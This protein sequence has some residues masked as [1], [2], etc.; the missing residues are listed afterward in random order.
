MSRPTT[1][2]PDRIDKNSADS[3][4]QGRDRVWEHRFV[5]LLLLAIAG[6]W[7]YTY[8]IGRVDNK[9]TLEILKHIRK[10]F[11]SHLVYIDRA[12]LQAGQSIT[13]EGIRIAKPT[14]QG[15]RDVVRC[16]RVVCLGPIELL[17]LAQGQM[18]VQSVVADG[19]EL[20]VWPLS[21]GRFSVQELTSQK[22]ISSAL[23]T[24]E[25]RS[26][27]VRIGS[28]TG[29]SEQE[30]ICHDLRVHAGLGP[31]MHEG[32]VLPITAQIEASVSSSFFRHAN[33]VA[34]V[35]EDKKSWAAQGK[36]DKL[37]YSPRLADQLP[38]VLQQYLT[39]AA[40]FSG[41]LN[42]VFA[43]RCDQGA[44]SFESK[45]NISN[46]RL[47]H[48]K[49]PYPLENLSGEVFC[50]NGLL[51]LRNVKAASGPASVA[52]A[53]DLHGYSM[54]SPLAASIHVQNLSLDQRL[55]QAIPAPIQ[56]TWRKL[57]VS[58][59]V[60]A[61]A[62]IQF[63]GQRWIPRATVHAK[64][65]QL[66]PEFF[67]YAV[68]NLTG[69]FVY[70][71]GSINAHNLTGL[72]G[73]QRISGSLSLVQ[74]QPRWL[75]DLKLAADGPIAIDEALLKA[76]SPRDAPQCAMHKFILS[77]HPTGTVLLKQGHFVRSA[78]KPDQISRSLELTFSECSIK[79]DGFRYPIAEVHG[80]ATIDNE[81]LLLKDFVGRNDGARIKGHGVCQFQNSSLDSMELSFDARD[82]NLDEELQRALP[83]SVRGL[84]D[85]MQPSGVLDRVAIEIKRKNSAALDM[86]VEI[87]E[88]RETES[89][90]GRAVSI[91]PV[92][93]PYLINDVACS[94]IYRPGIV[95]IKSL[96]G[97]HD[98]SCLK[99]KGQF[100]LNTDG[101]WSGLTWLSGTRLNVDQS[102]LNCLPSYLREPLVRLDFRGPVS[103]DGTTRVSSPPTPSESIVREW[104]L[105]LQLEDG[106]LGGGGIASGIRGTVLLAGENTV[107]GP[108][109]FGSLMLDALAIKNIA[110]TQV[111]GPFAFSSQELLFGREARAWQIKNNIR[112]PNF[113]N[114]AY[115]SSVVNANYVVPSTNRNPSNESIAQA[116]FRGNLHDSLSGKGPLLNRNQATQTPD[117][118][119]SS[120]AE[121]IPALDINEND[122]EARALSGTV[123]VSGVESLTGQHRG[124]YG[125]RLVDADLQGCLVDLGETNPQ[126]TGRLSIQSNLR[127]ALTNTTALEGEGR[128]WLRHANLYELPAMIRLLGMLSVSPSQGAFDSAD[129][130][131][132]IDGERIPVNELVLDGNIVSLRGNGWVNMRR[133]LHLNLFAHVGRRNLVGAIF[134]P[135]TNSKAARLWQIE[136]D[137]SLSDPQI[138]R[139]LLYSLDKVLPETESDSN[140]R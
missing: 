35:S 126:A 105:E 58:G 121:D 63:D 23:P 109:A 127:G 9:L 112:Q 81:H 15:V 103:I 27:L 129:I 85:Q 76:L 107:N 64:D 37:E 62:S 95:D 42:S 99:T 60:D 10:E 39:H 83:R 86:R 71:N 46:G 33:I 135:I 80:E 29:K 73:D 115:D 91:R 30:I 84:W 65:G 61:R 20:C 3:I 70:E 111:R 55:Y 41:E 119:A 24:I 49:V 123:Y 101:T 88:D 94:I 53:C 133:E 6:L 25:V 104:D 102:L 75:M 136:V 18:P 132:G 44:V 72:A 34:T 131:F 128:L 110:V 56:E 48:P 67:P 108:M 98:S 8:L 17:G 122:I 4:R 13:I 12:H 54:G 2:T 116:L 92:S 28:E 100:R 140:S 11:P 96:S 118:N 40:G 51:R 68:K 47:L 124:R 90:A 52:F 26:G 79:Y 43:A 31:R 14:D 137:G 87:N 134:R 113:S 69:D 77:L 7:G 114:S 22:P 32:K 89:Q 139:P 93:L 59:I 19:V 1:A 138:H 16:G 66:E 106:R 38:L 57:G 97:T 36:V 78:D 45:A 130:E 50:K 120:K 21:D 74:A 117:P 5:W 125:L 82:V